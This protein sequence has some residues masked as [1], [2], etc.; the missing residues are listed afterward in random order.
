MPV[1]A[2][3]FLSDHRG[4]AEWLI[5]SRLAPQLRTI[6][7][8]HV[9]LKLVN[10]RVLW[11]TNNV[12]RYRLAGVAPEAPNLKVHVTRVRRVTQV[13]LV[14]C[15]QAFDNSTPHT[16]ADQRPCGPPW[17]ARRTCGSWCRKGSGG[18]WCSPLMIPLIYTR[19]KPLGL[20]ESVGKTAVPWGPL[21]RLKRTSSGAGMK[22]C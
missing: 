1:R 10:R 8:P 19:W 21:R 2:A 5:A 22:F 13:A 17:H 20:G 14:P 4:V 7:A 16:R 12:E 18:T 11:S 9:A 3:L 6:L 15:S